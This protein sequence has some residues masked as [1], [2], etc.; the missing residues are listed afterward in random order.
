MM[1]S[2]GPI[3]SWIAVQS[4][5]LRKRAKGHLIQVVLFDLTTQMK[6]AVCLEQFEADEES[7]L[8]SKK[9]E[10]EGHWR[11]RNPVTSFK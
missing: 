1:M 11:E 2:V 9:K 4:K 7:Y 8:A 3:N 5:E 6:K 10:S